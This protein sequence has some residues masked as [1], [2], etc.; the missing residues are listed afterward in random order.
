[1]ALEMQLVCS[2]VAIP[3]VREKKAGKVVRKS[4]KLEAEFSRQHLGSRSRHAC[5]NKYDVFLFR[6]N[7]FCVSGFN[8]TPST[9]CFNVIHKPQTHILKNTH[10]N[11]YYTHISKIDTI[12]IGIA[13]IKSGTE[14]YFTSIALGYTVVDV[15]YMSVTKDDL[16][17]KY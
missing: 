4:T 1:M 10:T 8:L 2:G 12:R 16:Y 17:Y 15:S 3:E 11:F 5:A 9:E 13:S 14:L 6:C 7:Y